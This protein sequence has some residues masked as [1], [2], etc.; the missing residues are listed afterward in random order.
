MTKLTTLYSHTMM[1]WKQK[2]H[3]K[4][5]PMQPYPRE[6]GI[7]LDVPPEVQL[8]IYP[9]IVI[10]TRRES[11][12]SWISYIVETDAVI[13]AMTQIP[14]ASGILPPNTLAVGSVN[15]KPFFVLYRPAMKKETI[16]IAGIEKPQTI[17][18]PPLIWGGCGTDYRIWALNTPTYPTNDM[19]VMIAPFPNV[20]S[21][22]R[23]CWGDSDQRENAKI[24]TIEKM[25]ELFI[26][27]S[28]FNNH[29][30]NGKSARKPICILTLYP[31]LNVKYPLDDLRPA[32]PACIGEIVNGSVW[33]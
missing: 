2:K 19:P 4:Q 17:P 20:S 25:F 12:G 30:S 7:L 32:I 13:Q 9:N 33:R 3:K 21:D 27:G 26:R 28:K 14:S 16:T 6:A 5:N 1:R 29:L 24:T 10:L 8:D 15:G 11:T 22:G 23:I 18:T 31:E